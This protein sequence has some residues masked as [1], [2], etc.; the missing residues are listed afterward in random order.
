MR[1][2]FVQ[3][4]P[5]HNCKHFLYERTTCTIVIWKPVGGRCTWQCKNVLMLFYFMNLYPSLCHQKLCCCFDCSYDAVWVFQGWF[6]SC[7]R[8]VKQDPPPHWFWHHTCSFISA[9]S[10]NTKGGKKDPEAWGLVQSLSSRTEKRIG[11]LRRFW[12]IHGIH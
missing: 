11:T 2:G 1:V 3:F 10:E 6:L 9:H 7:L 4:L 12:Y 8:K 5:R